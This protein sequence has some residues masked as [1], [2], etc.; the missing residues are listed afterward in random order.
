MPR[1]GIR[2]AMEEVCGDGKLIPVH[3]FQATYE[4]IR[5]I[6][7]RMHCLFGIR[8]TMDNAVTGN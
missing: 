2:T 5:D 4:Y 8:T 7:F 6:L 3:H 1:F